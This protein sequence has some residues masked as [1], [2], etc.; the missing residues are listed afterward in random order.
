MKIHSSGSRYDADLAPAWA[1]GKEEMVDGEWSSGR[2]K[3]VHIR[4]PQAPPDSPYSLRLDLVVVAAVTLALARLHDLLR[5]SQRPRCGVVSDWD[6]ASPCR[7]QIRW[8]ATRAARTRHEEP[9]CVTFSHRATDR[10][11]DRKCI[12][13]TPGK[14]PFFLRPAPLSHISSF[15]S[16]PRFSTTAHLHSLPVA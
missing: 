4:R 6:L 13:P 12:G 9:W 5:R 8:T 1:D 16:P 3:H 10:V 15:P 2:M 7:H 11:I 14:P